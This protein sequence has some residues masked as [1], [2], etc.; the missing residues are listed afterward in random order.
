MREY[1]LGSKTMAWFP[2]ALSILA[3]DT[4]A[5]TYL[6]APAWAFR[7]NFK[8]N[9]GVFCFFLAIPIVIWLFLPVYSR[10]N[11]YTAYQFLEHRFN[12][13]VRLLTGLLFL[14][15]RGSHV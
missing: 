2:V 6:G 9:Q 12:L 1:L 13:S 10:A 11:L 3:A 4:S 14:L 7:E 15:V 8:L 5:L